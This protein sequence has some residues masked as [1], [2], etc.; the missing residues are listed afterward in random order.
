M[1]VEVYGDNFK[2]AAIVRI[3]EAGGVDHRE[4]ALDGHAAARL[5]EA[6]VA[7]GDGDGKPSGDGRAFKGLERDVY[8][9]HEVEA[10]ISFVGIGRQG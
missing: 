3:D 8:G 4:A 10:C 2:L 6:C 7:L 9:A 1:R 5:Y